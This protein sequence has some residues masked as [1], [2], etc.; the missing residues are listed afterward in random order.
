MKERLGSAPRTRKPQQ[1]N[2]QSACLK[3]C[4]L[5]IGPVFI[6][7]V[8]FVLQVCKGN[9]SEQ[10]RTGRTDFARGQVQ[11]DLDA[12]LHEQDEPVNEMKYEREGG[13]GQ[14]E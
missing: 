10:P 11:D 2:E 5:S 6:A 13:A 7:I 4:R 9:E 12:F 8:V 3:Q 14:S 1:K